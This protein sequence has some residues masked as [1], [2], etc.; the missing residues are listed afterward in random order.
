MNLIWKQNKYCPKGS[1]KR[2]QNIEKTES[3]LIK[4]KGNTLFDC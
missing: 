2:N 3:K 4:S 1:A